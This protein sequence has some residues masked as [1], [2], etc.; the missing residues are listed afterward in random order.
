[1]KMIE[2]I[3]T[4]G[5]L[6]AALIIVPNAAFAGQ[7]TTQEI[8]QEATVIGSGSRVNQRANQVSTQ[9]QERL[10]FGSRKRRC[11]VDTQ[12]QRSNQRIDQSAV[13]IDNGVVDQNAS[14]RNMQRQLILSSRRCY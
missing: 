10:R 4:L 1:M 9:R 12:S 14:Q 7:G 11:G 3:S 13:A 6:A 2:K 5:L 8:N